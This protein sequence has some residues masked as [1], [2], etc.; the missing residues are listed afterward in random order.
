MGDRVVLSAS[1]SAVRDSFDSIPYHWDD[2]MI[3]M[4]GNT[5]PVL[6]VLNGGIIAIPSP[7]GAQEGKWYFSLS[8]FTLISGKRYK[9][10]SH[11]LL[12]YFKF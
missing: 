7:D 11:S 10:L 12:L 9:L 4:L 2:L 3:H 6:A 8:T 1:E 5:Y